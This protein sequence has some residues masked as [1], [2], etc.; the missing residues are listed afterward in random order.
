MITCRIVTTMSKTMDTVVMTE[1]RRVTKSTWQVSMATPHVVMAQAVTWTWR[2]MMGMTWQSKRIKIWMSIMV[3]SKVGV[4]EA[5]RLQLKSVYRKLMQSNK[6][7][8][9]R[10]LEVK[11]MRM[12]RGRVGTLWGRLVVEVKVN[13]RSC[14]SCNSRRT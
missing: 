11:V 14:S 3:R 10:R 2:G 6:L 9:V 8:T 1:A 12:W 13:S 5:K 7:R 4:V